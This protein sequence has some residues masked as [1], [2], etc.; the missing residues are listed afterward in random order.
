MLLLK[1]CILYIFTI[2]SSY[3]MFALEHLGSKNNFQKE[4]LL[5]KKEIPCLLHTYSHCKDRFIFASFCKI[6]ICIIIKLR[7][8]MYSKL[9]NIFKR[10]ISANT[11][12][13]S[14]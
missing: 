11:V 14:E 1:A 5:S 10:K 3:H 8:L 13:S 7:V 2:V 9:I 6:L 4:T 12:V